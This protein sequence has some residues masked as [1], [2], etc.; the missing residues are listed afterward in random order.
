[1]DQF[2]APCDHIAKIKEKTVSNYKAQEEEEEKKEDEDR[3]SSQLFRSRFDRYLIQGSQVSLKP[4]LFNSAEN[5]SLTIIQDNLA[6]NNSNGMVGDF[7][8]LQILLGRSDQLHKII[9]LHPNI[10]HFSYLVVMF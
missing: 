9:H 2:R 7:N 5:L 8:E 1:M 6:F 10:L 4:N 3:V